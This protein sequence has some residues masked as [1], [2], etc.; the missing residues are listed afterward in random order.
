MEVE[1]KP[2]TTIRKFIRY[3]VP[4]IVEQFEKSQ[5]TALKITN[6]KMPKPDRVKL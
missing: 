3:S 1:Q 4:K 5:K 2:S 6:R